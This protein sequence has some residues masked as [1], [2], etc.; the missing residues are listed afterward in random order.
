M[1]FENLSPKK[2]ELIELI[3]SQPDPEYALKKATEVLEKIL[4]GEIKNAPF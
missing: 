1:E 2:R 3:L 4:N